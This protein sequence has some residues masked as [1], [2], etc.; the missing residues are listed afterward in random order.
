[1]D[2]GDLV[3]VVQ[4]ASH[5][6]MDMRIAACSMGLLFFTTVPVSWALGRGES[7][8]ITV[9]AG[10]VQTGMEEGI[11]MLGVHSGWGPGL[12]PAPGRSGRGKSGAG[13]VLSA[14]ATRHAQ[15]LCSHHY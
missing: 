10:L 7:S 13:R 5:G 14:E 4:G 12:G 15:F 11:R 9:S 3:R 8:R 6:G 2:E 1:M